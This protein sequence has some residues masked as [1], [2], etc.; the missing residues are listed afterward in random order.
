MIKKQIY[1]VFLN[2]LDL[3]YLS[4]SHSF[5]RWGKGGGLGPVGYYITILLTGIC[6]IFV[7]FRF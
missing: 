3:P 5:L 7:G 4:D 1:S 6:G 2:F